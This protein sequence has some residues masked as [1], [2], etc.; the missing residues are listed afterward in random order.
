MLYAI[1]KRD[2]FHDLSV[3]EFTFHVESTVALSFCVPRLTP[4]LVTVDGISDA[5]RSSI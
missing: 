5:Q 1:F 2:F 3:Q 4:L